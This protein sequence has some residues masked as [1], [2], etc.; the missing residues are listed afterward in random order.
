MSSGLELILNASTATSSPGGANTARVQNDV[1]DL[2]L[3]AQ[4]NVG[5]RVSATTGNVGICKTAGTGALDV[6]GNVNASGLTGCITNSVSTS[7]STVAASATAV[8]AANDLAT[9]ALPKSGGAVTGTLA[10]N[11]TSVTGTYALDVSGGV[12]VSGTITTGNACGL[13][14]WK[15][16]GNTPTYSSSAAVEGSYSYPSGCTFTNLVAYY[17][18]YVNGSTSMVFNN[19]VGGSWTTYLYANTSGFHIGVGANA[20]GATFMPFTIILVTIA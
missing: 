1:G 2:V 7:S 16:T 12:A 18:S 15:V 11:K 19:A 10:V 13:M 14:Y 8:K 4:G 17:G 6:S 3:W 20:T 5:L 9:L